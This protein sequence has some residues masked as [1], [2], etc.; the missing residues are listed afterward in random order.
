MLTQEEVERI[1]RE[2]SAFPERKAACID[3]LRILQESR[4]W[5]DDGSIRDLAQLLRM[6]PTEVEAVATFYN[7]IFRRPVGRH[8]VHACDS[9]SC[10]ILGA[11]RLR[12]RIADH[13]GVALGETTGDGRFTLLPIA[14]LGAC[15]RAPA[16][17]ID[18]RLHGNVDAAELPR[19][20]EEYE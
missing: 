15:D 13:L 10:W 17:M 12:R 7:L 20:F 8:V 16:L 1:E 3:A 4:R 11:D 18:D 2:T 19:L 9:V 5:I 6:D 14:C